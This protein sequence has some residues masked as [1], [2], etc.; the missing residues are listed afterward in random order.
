M[1]NG[2]K[3]KLNDRREL[4]LIMPA[5][6]EETDIDSVIEKV[7]DVVSR[8][9]M[10]YE[11]IVV[12][13][14]SIDNTRVKIENYARKNGHVKV[15]GYENNVGKGYALKTGF[16]HAVGD[17]VVFM[18]SDSDID[19]KQVWR[20]LEALKDAD[21]VVSSK[22]HSQSKVDIPLIRKILSYG[23]NV[24]VKLFVGLRLNDTQ[25]GLKAVR[26]SALVGVFPNLTVKRYAFDVELL[27]LANLFGLKI[28]ELPINVRLRS[29][30]SIREVW[31]MFLDLLEITYRLRV[32]RWYQR[33]LPNYYV[34]TV[35]AF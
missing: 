25:T 31:K 6:N 27:T 28:V 24:L 4:S 10:K 14:G 5:Y 32:I 1:E 23:F 30:F 29:L 3:R 2:R 9:G 22:R 17:L 12:D 34:K 35:E 15:V 33:V 20:Y 11:L 7:D 26:R 19:P 21:V 13:D 16:S 18:D 8:M